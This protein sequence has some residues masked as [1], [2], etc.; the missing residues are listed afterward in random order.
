MTVK[1]RE[2]KV[3]P[4]HFHLCVRKR[5]TRLV[6]VD[7]LPTEEALS[8]KKSAENAVTPLQTENNGV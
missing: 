4:A 8:A 5:L 6:L 7:T 3:P 2:N 1:D